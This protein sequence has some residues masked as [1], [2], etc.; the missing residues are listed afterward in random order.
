MKF[1]DGLDEFIF[2][3]VVLNILFFV[4]EP[5]FTKVISWTFVL[6]R[7]IRNFFERILPYIIVKPRAI[8]IC[9]R[10]FSTKRLVIITKF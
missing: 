6:S 4:S 1:W 2:H 9:L 10:C 7:W 3:D 5:G 8:W